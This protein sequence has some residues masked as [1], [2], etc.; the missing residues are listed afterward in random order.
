M[1]THILLLAIIVSTFLSSCAVVNKT[2]TIKK[3]DIYGAGV[4]QKP[5]IVDLDVKE[6]K[7]SGTV[8]GGTYNS[9]IEPL[10]HLAV[11]DLLKKENADV[12]VEPK[13]EIETSGGQLTVTVTGW[14]A[15]YT[16]FR[17]ITKDDVELMKVGLLQKADV[18]EAPKTE[19]KKKSPIAAVLGVIMGV[20]V[21]VLVVNR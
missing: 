18:Y 5:V 6:T 7:V 17:P 20:L 13:F 9:E 16:N 10:K 3:M 21:A 14:P 11:A 8:T 2:N 12:L 4:I 19:Q 15:T 1:K